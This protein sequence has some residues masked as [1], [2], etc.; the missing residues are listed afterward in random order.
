[1]NNF[2]IVE[3]IIRPEYKD[4][5]KS[6]KQKKEDIKEDDFFIG[7][8]DDEPIILDNSITNTHTLIVGPNYSVFLD[9]IL[10]TLLKTNKGMIFLEDFSTLNIQEIIY[11]TSKVNNIDKL[12]FFSFSNELPFEKIPKIPFQIILSLYE[13]EFI[14]DFFMSESNLYNLKDKVIL[15][16]F[17]QFLK[18][19]NQELFDKNNFSI[20]ERFFN[21]KN[22]EKYHILK[23]LPKKSEQLLYQD[24]ESLS[25]FHKRLQKVISYIDLFNE[26]DI[27]FD[28]ETGCQIWNDL[29][30][31]YK[32]FFDTKHPCAGIVI[33]IL[34]Y[35]L[36]RN[37]C[38]RHNA[39]KNDPDK[40]N[41]TNNCMVWKNKQLPGIDVI[42]PIDQV[43]EIKGIGLI[44]A[45][46]R[47]LNVAMFYTIPYLSKTNT[48]NTILEETTYENLNIHELSLEKKSIIA[49]TNTKIIM[50]PND[51]Y[52]LIHLDK[53]IKNISKNNSLY[54]FDNSFYSSIVKP[55]KI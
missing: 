33:Q 1:M 51:K 11:K 2:K 6:I 35:I 9:N 21:M 18:E 39:Y 24:N 31:N 46:A 13:Y 7:Y 26:D 16:D 42:Y 50:E 32:C 54:G 14:F 10:Y 3:K 43:M 47:A 36:G 17:K 15:L 19:W 30:F 12:R 40:L 22:V 38:Y 37:F 41:K 28:T 29:L 55:I 52:T 44:S 45:Q 23:D 4:N 20:T 27:I 53:I 48:E 5:K 49:N 25:K 34:K 8:K